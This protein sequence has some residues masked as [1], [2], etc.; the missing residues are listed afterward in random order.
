MNK[1]NMIRII[2]CE[3]KYGM[4]NEDIESLAEYLI[5]EEKIN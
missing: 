4:C 2:T 3:C 1:Y 5:K